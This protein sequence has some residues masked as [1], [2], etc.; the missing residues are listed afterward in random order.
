PLSNSSPELSPELFESMW[1]LFIA[2]VSYWGTMTDVSPHRT[3]LLN[4]MSNRIKLD[5]MYLE[6]Y[7]T[8]AQVVKDLTEEF[9]DG[10]YRELFTNAVADTENP[11]QTPMGI[12]RQ[13]VSNEFV[14]MQLVFGGFRVF[15]AVNYPGFICGPNIPGA[16]PPY[17]TGEEQ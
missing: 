14:S 11:P 9:G 4:F 12:A 8:A 2:G 16:A 3:Q 15:G 17:R 6:Y 5:P 1:A 10:A 13:R 7:A